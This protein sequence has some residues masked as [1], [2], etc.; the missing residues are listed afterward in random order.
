MTSNIKELDPVQGLIDYIEDIK[1]YHTKVVEVLTEYVYNELID[2]TIT[3]RFE[4]AMEMIYP[5]PELQDEILALCG[6]GGG[7]PW[8][9]FTA[10][11]VIPENVTLVLGPFDDT[12]AG[13]DIVADTVKITGDRT[14]QYLVGRDIT[15]DLYAVDTV[16]DTRTVGVQT[17]YTVTAAEF[18]TFGQINGIANTEHTVL[19]VTGLLDPTVALPPLGINEVYAAGVNF[20]PYPIDSVVGYSSAAPVFYTDVPPGADP[21]PTPTVGS[22]SQTP[23]E[24]PGALIFSNSFVLLGDFAG[25][26]PQ[27]FMLNVIGGT[28]EGEYTVKY[29]FYDSVGDKT[30]IRVV[31]EIDTVGFVTGD[32]HERFFGY[33][34]CAINQA[35]VPVG[36]TNTQMVESLVFSWSI[37]ASVTD[38]IDGFQFFVNE[39]VTGTFTFRV[40]GDAT[41]DIF[42]TD[43]IRLIGSHT[44]DGVYTVSGAP[45]FVLPYTDITVVEAI[46]DTQTG[47]TEYAIREG[48]SEFNYDGVG[49]NGTFVGGDGA[50]GTAYVALDTI[51]L[52]D[53]SIVTVNVVDGNG[54]V[55]DFGITTSGNTVVTLGVALTQSSTSGTGTAFTLTPELAN[56]FSTARGWV[57]K[58]AP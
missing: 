39:A 10:W 42:D 5:S 11:P 48:Q 19:T 2:T 31:E 57:E 12:P 21:L 40:N 43:S 51:T 7:N 22:L 4:S 3:E 14:S 37:P 55:I 24:N 50:G 18:V 53:G 35:N 23:D 46:P 6:F 58:F 16:L 15:I 26:F 49:L 17:V 41:G 33:D 8:D 34:E 36:L 44:N 54:D 45:V 38:I 32:I 27:G 29:A 52:S 25:S 13:Y 9:G 1:P 30:Y 47:T 28:T 20:D 56:G